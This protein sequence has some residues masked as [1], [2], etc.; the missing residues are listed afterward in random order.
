MIKTD[1]N[2]VQRINLS[3]LKFQLSNTNNNFKIIIA[4]I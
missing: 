4:F 1:V 3:I 2:F